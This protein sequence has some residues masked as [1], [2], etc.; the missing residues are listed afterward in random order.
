MLIWGGL[1]TDITPLEDGAA[2][3]PARDSWRPLEPV[4]L[5]GRGFPMSVWDGRGMIVWGG[6]VVVSVPASAA[7]GARYAP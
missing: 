3:D 5:L 4:P 1:G 7:D 6:L 2:Y